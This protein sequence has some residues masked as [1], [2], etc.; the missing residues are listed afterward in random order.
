MPATLTVLLAA[1]LAD[2]LQVAELAKSYRS[3]LM[4]GLV[5]GAAVLASS[6]F[7]LAVPL[8]LLWIATAARPLAMRARDAGCLLAAA[9]L[10]VLPVTLRNRAVSD[11]WVLVATNGGITFWQGNNPAARGT[12]RRRKAS[13]ARSIPNATRHAPSRRET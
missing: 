7:V 4:V 2:R 13:P 5:L 8:T 12:L 11:E 9:A 1:L 6:A 10:V 3:W